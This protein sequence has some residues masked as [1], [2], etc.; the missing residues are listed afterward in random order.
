MIQKY[1]DVLVAHDLEPEAMVND[2]RDTLE[3]M[4]PKIN[5]YLKENQSEIVKSVGWLF[6]STWHMDGKEM[7]KILSATTGVVCTCRYRQI[8]NVK[9]MTPFKG[10]R[11]EII[12][13]TKAIHVETDETKFRK[14]K[15][16]M[17]NYNSSTRPRFV[18]GALLRFVPEFQP[19]KMTTTVKNSI[20]NLAHMQYQ[21]CSGGTKY[22]PIEGLMGELGQKVQLQDQDV[23]TIREII[24]SI[25]SHDDPQRFPFLFHALEHLKDGPVVIYQTTVHDE[26]S[27]MAEHM[28]EFLKWKHGKKFVKQFFDLEVLREKKQSKWDQD[29]WGVISSEDKEFAAVVNDNYFVT[30]KMSFDLSAMQREGKKKQ[31]DENSSATSYHLNDTDIQT[32]ASGGSDNSITSNNNML[33]SMKAVQIHAPLNAPQRSTPK[34]ILKKKQDKHAAII[35][36]LRNDCGDNQDSFD[37]AIKA[38]ESQGIIPPGTSG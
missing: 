22:A 35:A 34:P 12:K 24:L 36:R 33:N 10:A 30:N 26:A 29:A 17:E 9:L 7:G 18:N 20:F 15:K 19:N 11:Q 27:Y 14:V 2:V 38:L 31:G 25:P 23:T 3:C 21:A 32:I 13:A 4:T 8:S 16:F 28:V 6:L 37:L 1:V 5:I